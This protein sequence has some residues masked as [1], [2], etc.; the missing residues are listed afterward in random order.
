M[1]P[2]RKPASEEHASPRKASIVQVAK[3]VFFSF[4]G[5]RRRVGYESDAASITPVQAIVAGVIG[6]AILLAGLLFLVSIVTK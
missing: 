2:S 6:A 3:A 4:I 5:V 1:K